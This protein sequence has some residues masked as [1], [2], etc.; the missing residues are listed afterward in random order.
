MTKAFG[1]TFDAGNTTTLTITLHN[2]STTTALSGATISDTLPSPLT[3]TTAATPQ[4]G[5]GTV[6]LST[7]TLTNDTIN[8]TGGVIPINGTCTITGTV[9][10]PL[11]MST[12][13]VTNTIPAGA[14][15]TTQ[16]ATNAAPA[17]ANVT[18]QSITVTKAFSGA[19]PAGGTATLT[20]TLTNLTASPYTGAAIS[21]KLPS[22][23]TFTAAAGAQCSGTVTLS[24]T[25]TT[26]D[27][28]NLAG[29]TIPAGGNCTIIGTVTAPSNSTPGTYTNT[30][31]ALALTT[32]QGAS[33]SVAATASATLQAVTITK[34]FAP[35][36]IPGDGVT[37]STLTI[38]VNNQTSVNLTNAAL[39][40]TLPA[41]PNTDLSVVSGFGSHHLYRWNSYHDRAP[42]GKFSR[43]HDQRPVRLV[44]LR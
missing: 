29:G 30:I 7:T 40:D 2:P 6:S 28:I 3:F 26:N 11:S 25:T 15:T 22:P 31:P 23:L 17:T 38:T 36:S 44:R 12:A 34:A 19:I 13:T 21:D 35:A 9:T 43:C 27:T 4:C 32:T 5:G 37:P 33:N 10:A 16:G 24:T 20:I 18:V 14:L 41:L 39:T 42:H 1:G 8:L